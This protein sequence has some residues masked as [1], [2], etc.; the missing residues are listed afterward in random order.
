M[1]PLISSPSAPAPQRC[2]VL[3]SGWWHDDVTNGE[4]REHKCHP[5]QGGEFDC[6]TD[7]PPTKPA[8]KRARRARARSAHVEA[9]RKRGAWQIASLEG[10][11]GGLLGGR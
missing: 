5:Y 3:D 2:G 11:A 1:V 4:K 8:S 9:P 7:D 6:M 10:I